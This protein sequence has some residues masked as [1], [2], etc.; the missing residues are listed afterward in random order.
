MNANF[1]IATVKTRPAICLWSGKGAE[2]PPSD[3]PIQGTFSVLKGRA[4][5]SPFEGLFFFLPPVQSRA[6]WAKSP[7]TSA[8]LC[9]RQRGRR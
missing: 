8:K 3:V 1:T 4:F 5:L 2:V 9:D 7:N 6:A